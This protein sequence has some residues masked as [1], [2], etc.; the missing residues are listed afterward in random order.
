M[1]NVWKG[2]NWKYDT[3]M[4]GEETQKEKEGLML[5]FFMRVTV[6]AIQFSIEDHHAISSS[7]CSFLS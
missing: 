1:E 4:M 3:L 5:E 6:R 2:D 7:S